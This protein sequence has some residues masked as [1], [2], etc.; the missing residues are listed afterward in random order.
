[1]RIPIDGIE[2]EMTVDEYLEY[3]DKTGGY[4]L[5][6]ASNGRFV[7]G[8][9]QVV[10]P[11]RESHTPP[12]EL[13]KES[14]LPSAVTIYD[15]MEQAEATPKAKDLRK[16][17]RIKR[18]EGANGHPKFKARLESGWVSVRCIGPKELLVLLVIRHLHNSYTEQGLPAVLHRNSMA[19]F[20]ECDPKEIQTALSS[21]HRKKFITQ[22][23]KNAWYLT[24]LGATA[25]LVVGTERKSSG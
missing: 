2:V 13:P 7:A 8:S 24:K 10:P 18:S 9:L 12:T 23:V 19:G 25:K 11:L 21:L 16:A 17:K 22:D 14:K 20:M 3:R 1:M 5:Q 4:R 15:I 6:K